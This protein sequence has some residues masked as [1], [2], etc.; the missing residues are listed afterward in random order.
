MPFL[1]KIS[2]LSGKGMPKD[3]GETSVLT[4]FCHR[5]LDLWV[6]SFK[7]VSRATCVC[8]LLLMLENQLLLDWK[9]SRLCN[10]SSLLEPQT[11]YLK[12]KTDCLKQRPWEILFLLQLHD[13][14]L[15]TLYPFSLNHED[16]YIYREWLNWLT[17]H[18]RPLPLP[19]RWFAA[20]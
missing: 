8:R 19:V 14:I 15:F 12:W 13:F 17:L 11:S 7:T 4:E 18:T 3:R 10:Y 16:I 9:P 2:D 1:G 6:T 5:C 20:S